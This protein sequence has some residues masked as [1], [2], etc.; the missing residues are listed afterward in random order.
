VC[1]DV[2]TLLTIEP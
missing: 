1:D 2:S